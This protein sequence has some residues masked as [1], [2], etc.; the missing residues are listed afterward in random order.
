MSYQPLRQK[1]KSWG[2]SVPI[3]MHVPGHKNG[4]IG[5]LSFTKPQYDVTEITGFDDLHHADDVLYQSMQTLDQHPNYKGYYLVNG[6]TSGILAVIHA[7]ANRKGTVSIARNVHKSVFNALDIG[8]QS[9][10]IMP[11]SMSAQTNQYLVPEVNTSIKTDYKLGVVTYP[12]YYGETYDIEKVIRDYHAIS[13]PVLVDEAHGAHFGLDGFPASSMND[14]ADYVVQS[15]H[16]T[17]PSLTMSSILWIHKDAPYRAQIELLLQ[18]FQSSSPSYLLLESLESAQTFYRHYQSD[19]FFKKREILIEK[20]KESAFE[21]IES[22]DPLKLVIRCKGWSGQEIQ[23]LMEENAIY[24]ELADEQSVLWVLPL[25]HVDDRYPFALLLQRIARMKIGAVREITQ[26]G[27]APMLYSQAGEYNAVAPNSF[28][29]MSFEHAYGKILAAHLIP[30]PPGVPSLLRG[31]KMT[32]DMI[33]LIHY[34]QTRGI[35]I[36]GLTNGKIKVEDE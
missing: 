20:L 9:A 23:A 16:K 18:T 24:V 1:M 14:D 6:T 25:W 30:Y 7:F 31:E 19:Y 8:G 33:K 5:D 2:Q 26:H 22:Q 4:T 34:W 29:E 36:E 10:N 12:N 27:Q 17:L 3:S 35:R 32:K 28:V 15:Y 13:V 11:T 21:V